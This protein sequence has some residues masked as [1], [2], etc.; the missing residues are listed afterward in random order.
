MM[1]F[2]LFVFFEWLRRIWV[3]LILEGF[4]L[5]GRKY[6][7]YYLL[8]LLSF[9]DGVGVERVAKLE[10]DYISM[11]FGRFISATAFLYPLWSLKNGRRF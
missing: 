9:L 3:G 2:F 4:F 5:F 6:Q 8:D 11:A 10:I 1:G 7:L